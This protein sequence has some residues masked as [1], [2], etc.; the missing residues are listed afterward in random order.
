MRPR[1]GSDRGRASAA[2]T[3]RVSDANAATRRARRR[4]GL[5]Q[6]R[7]P[8][9]VG[10]PGQ[11]TAWRRASRVAASS[12][13]E[14]LVAGPERGDLVLQLED[15]A[16]ALDADAA[17]GE[18]GDLAEQLDVA[19]AVAAAAAA[20]AAR[21]DQAHPLVGAQ[22]L[23]VQPGQL[24]GHADHV[25]RRRRRRAG[26]GRRCASCT[27]SRRGWRAAWCRTPAAR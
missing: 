24:G 20:G 1:T 9:R 2:Q 14:L 26:P 18:R 6:D 10:R 25:D 17:G 19:V 15:P 11:L 21:H 4:V 16:Y 8:V 22:G 3:S 12:V 13:G 7:Q 5:A 23:R 27:A